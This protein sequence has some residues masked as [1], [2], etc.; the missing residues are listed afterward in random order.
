MARGGPAK[1]MKT[2]NGIQVE[3]T[4]WTASST[5]RILQYLGKCPKSKPADCSEVDRVPVLEVLLERRRS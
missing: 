5:E 3:S 4:I 2:R 1:A